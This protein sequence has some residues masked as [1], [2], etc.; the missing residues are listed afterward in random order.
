MRPRKEFA[1]RRVTRPLLDLCRRI[2]RPVNVNGSISDNAIKFVKCNDFT[3]HSSS[4]SPSS[5]SQ[6]PLQQ[7]HSTQI[8][9]GTSPH[10]VHSSKSSLL[11]R[12]ALSEATEMPLLL[13]MHQ[14]D[15]AHRELREAVRSAQ[16]SPKR[17]N[18]CHVHTRPRAL[19]AHRQS[20]QMPR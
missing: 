5:Q 7:P 16:R 13:R 2:T 20:V 3:F 6:H 8:S 14:V 1:V 4:S 15:H 12:L 17:M 11:R 9:E 18:V 10:S 19:Q